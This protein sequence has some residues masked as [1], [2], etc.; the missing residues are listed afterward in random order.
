MNGCDL[1][2]FH[3]LNF[4]QNLCYYD[5]A[6]EKDDNEDNDEIHLVIEPTQSSVNDDEIH[7][8]S[9]SETQFE[10][11]KESDDDDDDEICMQRIPR[12]RKWF[13]EEGECCIVLD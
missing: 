12:K 3:H 8:E 1:M 2:V 7:Q 11:N 5:Y 9:Q 4:I 13:N 10:K 6:A